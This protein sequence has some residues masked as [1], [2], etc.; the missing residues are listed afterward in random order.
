MQCPVC[1]GDMQLVNGI[2]K[3]SGKP[4]TAN[5]CLNKGCKNAQGFRTRVFVNTPRPQGN[6]SASQPVT[7]THAESMAQ[8][9]KSISNTLTQIYTLLNLKNDP[10]ERS[11]EGPE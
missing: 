3:E 4:W 7:S 11:M 6:M 10:L 5:E 2:G 8:S 1:K 9:L